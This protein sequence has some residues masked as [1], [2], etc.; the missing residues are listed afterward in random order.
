[1][2]IFEEYGAYVIW[3]PE[4]LSISQGCL[5]YYEDFQNIAVLNLFSTYNFNQSTGS[6]GG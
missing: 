6:T 5:F 3:S 1:M 4:I 2:S